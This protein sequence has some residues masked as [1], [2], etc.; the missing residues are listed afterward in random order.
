[1]TGRTMTAIC[2]GGPRVDVS[3]RYIDSLAEFINGEELLTQRTSFNPARFEVKRV[4]K[5]KKRFFLAFL[6]AD[7]FS[8][9][10][11]QLYCVILL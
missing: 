8:N 10:D 6:T 5:C 2:H 3:Q 11:L 1:M 7:S 9:A 4:P